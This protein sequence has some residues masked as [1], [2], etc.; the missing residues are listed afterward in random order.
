MRAF[1]AGLQPLVQSGLCRT[2]YRREDG[3]LEPALARSGLV[4]SAAAAAA[5]AVAAAGV[6]PAR[7]RFALVGDGGVGRDLGEAVAAR[8]LRRVDGGLSAEADVL[9]LADREPVVGPGQAASV[10]ARVV[11]PF[12]EA[13]FAPAAAGRL[14]ERGVAVLPADVVAGGL[15]AALDLS[16]RGLGESEAVERIANRAAALATSPRLRAL[17]L[18]GPA[19]S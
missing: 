11:L 2:S 12:E 6:A 17:A 15:L 8:G 16:A 18:L 14:A 10:R 13:V 19:D 9:L 4:A 7:A 5:A 3:R 1:V